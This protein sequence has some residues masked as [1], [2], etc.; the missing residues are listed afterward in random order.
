[1]KK[2]ERQI[3][4]FLLFL[5]I[6]FK[7]N[8]VNISNYEITDK[9]KILFIRLNN[10]GDALIATPVIKRIKE[11]TNCKTYVLSSKRNVQ[12]FNR[13][14]YV[15][16]TIIFNKEFV[17]YREILSFIKK[18]GIEI[19]VDLHDD[20]SVTVTYLV[21]LSSVKV[22]AGLKKKFNTVYNLSVE[23]KDAVHFHIVERL[24]ELVTL[25]NISYSK[26]ET[27]VVFEPLPRSFESADKF[28][29]DSF[30]EKKF[31]LG[32]NISAGGEARFWGVDKYRTLIELIQNE[33]VNLFL[34]CSPK[35]SALAEQIS[36][37]KI[38]HFAP[39]F[40]TMAATVSKLDLLIS[41]DTSVVH[42]ASAFK[43]PLFG[44][45]VHYNTEE[46][47]WSPYGSPFSCVITKEANL[48]NVTVEHVWEKLLPFINDIKKS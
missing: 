33:N 29:S 47:I 22:K 43:I 5:L 4:R 16:H 23:R 11:E 48:K 21:A 17:G 7:K 20:V 10:L 45:Y 24:M 30:K 18:E 15:D 27:K 8:P 38:P 36:G 28:L 3:K 25:F 41:P 32:I 35:E 26:E 2:I 31:L 37:L 9:T 1:M 13:N 46:M 6:L 14:R 19:I 39:D 44:L 12:V 40:D 42:I 34:F